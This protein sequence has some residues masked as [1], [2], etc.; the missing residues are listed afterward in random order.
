MKTFRV[1][2]GKASEGRHKDNNKRHFRSRL[3]T[4][5]FLEVQ[6]GQSQTLTVGEVDENMLQ[7]LASRDFIAITEQTAQT[8]QPARQSR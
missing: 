7:N 2:L 6:E 4:G 8:A 5:S 1:T 3:S